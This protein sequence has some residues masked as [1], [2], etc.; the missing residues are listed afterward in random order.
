[1]GVSEMGV[2]GTMML[3]LE[4]YLKERTIAV[5]LSSSPEVVS[6]YVPITSGVPQKSDLGPLLFVLFVNDLRDR[7]EGCEFLCPSAKS[8]RLV[9]GLG[10]EYESKTTW[11]PAVC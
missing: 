7:L 3:S 8:S 2:S 4:S 1:M 9:A 10:L 6:N 5:R 11:L